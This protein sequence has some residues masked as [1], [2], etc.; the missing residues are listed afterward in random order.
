VPP[1]VGWGYLAFVLGCGAL[2]TPVIRRRL[3]P[4]PALGTTR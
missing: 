4:R 1:H 2:L 3:R